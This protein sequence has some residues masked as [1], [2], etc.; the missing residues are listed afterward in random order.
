MRHTTLTMMNHYASLNVKELQQS[1]DL[2][3]PPRTKDIGNDRESSGA[4]YWDI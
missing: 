3:S 2:Y 1:H 4:D